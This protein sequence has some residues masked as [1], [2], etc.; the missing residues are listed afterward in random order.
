MLQSGIDY[1][2]AILQNAGS[3]QGK[4]LLSPVMFVIIHAPTAASYAGTVRF[5]P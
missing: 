2:T 5:P 1:R 3:A 4:F